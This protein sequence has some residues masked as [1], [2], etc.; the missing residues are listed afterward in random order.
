LSAVEAS[1][2]DKASSATA[3]GDATVTPAASSPAP[4]S[5][6]V[7]EHVA[8]AALVP[9]I[10]RAIL[11]VGRPLSRG[12]VVKALSDRGIRVG[13]DNP[14]TNVGTIMWRAKGDFVNLKPHGYWPRDVSYARAGYDPAKNQDAEPDD[15]D[16]KEN[17]SAAASGGA[18]AHLW[19]TSRQ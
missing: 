5:E 6:Q 18:N 13:G 8:G 14:A 12:D 15:E 9:H 19:A 7:S 17:G 10:R 3:E 4:S 16:H 11:D 2:A 1:G